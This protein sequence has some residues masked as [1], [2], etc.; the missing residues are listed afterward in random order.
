MGKLLTK[1][2]DRAPLEESRKWGLYYTTNLLFKTYFKVDLPFWPRYGIQEL[3]PY[4]WIQLVCPKIFYG[5]LKPPRRTC[6]R[7]KPSP[8]PTLWLSITTSES[9]FSWTRIMFRYWFS[10]PHNP[11]TV[12]SR[13]NPW[14]LSRQKKTSRMPSTCATETHIETKSLNPIPFFH[15][16]RLFTNNHNNRL[17]DSSSPI[18]SP[19]TS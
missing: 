5:P 8:N 4:S 18:S 13:T 17:P 11:L 10:A 9:F 19:V 14:P 12:H 1:F 15:I 3:K 2:P 6:P 16:F 7:W